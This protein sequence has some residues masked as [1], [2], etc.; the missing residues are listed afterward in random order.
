MKNYTVLIL[1]IKF[2]LVD[3]DGN[4]LQDDNGNTIGYRL[5]EGI[6]FKPLEYL[7][8]DMDTDI[9]EQIKK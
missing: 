6:R 3:E 1:D 8:D 4:D 7:T 9:L 5:K 2:Y